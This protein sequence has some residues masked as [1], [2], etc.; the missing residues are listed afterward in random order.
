MRVAGAGHAVFAATMV[1]L[2]VQGLVRGDFTA[3]WQPVSAGVTGRELLA[4]LC[5]GISLASG[6][7]LLWALTAAH[8]A[9]LLL[10]WLLLWFLLFRLPEIFLAPSAAV[11][12][13]GAGET[14]V[15][16]AGAWVLYA[17]FAADGRRPAFAGGKTGVRIARALYGLAMIAFGQAHFA[18]V[19]YTAALVPAWLPSHVAWVYFTGGAYI[20]AG[21]AILVGVCARLAA[22]LSA[23]QMGVF[24]LLVWVPVVVAGARDA[25]QWLEAATSWAL[26]AA[27]WVVADSYRGLPWLGAGKR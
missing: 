25:S 4:Y 24:T 6:A 14:V 16:V 2:G 1:A 3:I 22:S 27:A 19:N 9:R 10:L 26:T 23:L 8:A 5:A 21:A 18:Y 12:W 17:W 20:A 15:I 7:G 11:T 13:E